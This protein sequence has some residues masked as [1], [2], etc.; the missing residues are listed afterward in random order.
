M[1]INPTSEI[2]L[3]REVTPQP[4]DP[5]KL[6]RVVRRH[7]AGNRAAT[8]ISYGTRK[9]KEP[10]SVINWGSVLNAAKTQQNQ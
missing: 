3:Q 6:P 10:K 9:P 4:A 7:V 2:N 8:Q 1:P 5:T